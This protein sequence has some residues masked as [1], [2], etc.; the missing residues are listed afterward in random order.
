MNSCGRKVIYTDE[1]E[2]NRE[3]I[4][5]VLSEALVQH[6]GNASDCDFL[7]NY[8]AGRQ[9]KIREKKYRKEVDCWVVDN[10]A[11]EVVEFW[12]SFFWSNPISFVQRGEKDSGSD[13][14]T[15]SIAMLNELYDLDGIK[16]KR[17]ELAGFVEKT[18]IGYTLT[19][20]NKRYEE[21]ENAPFI[22]TV[23]DPRNSFVVRS[24]R[25]T[26]KRVV[27]G[28]TYYTDKSGYR[29]FTCYTP[30]RVYLIKNV[31]EVV[32]GKATSEW[33]ELERSGEK[34][35]FGVI[36]IVEYI[37]NHD[38]M[39]VFERQI[40]EMNNLNLMISDFSNDVDQNTQCVWFGVNIEFP[41][42]EVTGERIKPKDGDWILA[43][44]TPQGHPSAQGLAVNYDY[45]GMLENIES[46]REMI[47]QKCN[48][49]QRKTSSSGSSGVAMS[50]ASGWT[51]AESCAVKQQSITEQSLMEEARVV[52]KVIKKSNKKEF[53]KMNALR[54]IDIQ[55][56]LKRQKTYEMTTKINA[57]ATGV[58]HGL[59]G[60]HMIKVI[61]LFDDP[62]Q[63]WEDSKE[64]ILE[65]Q[66][67]QFGE[68]QQQQ[69]TVEYRPD[70]D[71]L[72]QDESDQEKNSP[73]IGG[74]QIDKTKTTV[75]QPMKEKKE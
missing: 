6:I 34:N 25:Y 14:E 38:R 4:V 19:E 50:D 32:D 64:S 41:K 47:L 45:K 27:L 39:G 18:G 40:D 66:E 7:I 48:V 13:K 36:P 35:P 57:F 72:N 53:A 61:N 2:V 75:E 31:V 15:E 52:L 24:T 67:K 22:I 16:S 65:F 9:P 56:N 1:L 30:D 70:A 62:N 68:N 11:N 69:Q 74:G 23:L 51:Q 46:R 43:N 49:P 5:A 8:E 44:S 55:P 33:G 59:S 63:V 54:L 60:Y 71:K 3:N 29:Y 21:G 20:I 42:D 58:A 26:D 37:K 12:T 73:T 28:V 17:Q 10:V